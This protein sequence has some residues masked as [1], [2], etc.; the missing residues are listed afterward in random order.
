M[1]AIAAADSG[2]QTLLEAPRCGKGPGDHAAD[3]GDCGDAECGHPR[4]CVPV[5]LGERAD[6]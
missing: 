4:S 3:A 6:G 2:H 5:G 1:C